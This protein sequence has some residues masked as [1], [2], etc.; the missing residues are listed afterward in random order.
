MGTGKTTIG[1]IIAQKCGLRFIE[2]DALIEERE[3][4]SIAQ[5][6]KEKG[7]DFF[8]GLEIKLVKEIALT[9]DRV[10]SCGGGLIC[11]QTNLTLLASSGVLIC[12]TASI[13]TIYERTKHYQHRPLLNVENPHQVI[14]ELLVQ[15]KRFYAQAHYTVNTDR[16]SP[17]AVA[18]E[19]IRITAAQHT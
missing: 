12:L 2:T 19:V 3:R 18:C 6:F 11:N 5:I 16:I 15:R 13:E 1:K 4:C 10:V 8:R 7:E 17:E 9:S 14:Q